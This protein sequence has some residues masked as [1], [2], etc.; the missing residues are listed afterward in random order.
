MRPSGFALDTG[1]TAS[2][3][4]SLTLML[5]IACAVAATGAV[6]SIGL[7]AVALVRNTPILWSIFAVFGFTLAARVCCSGLASLRQSSCG[8]ERAGR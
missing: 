1:H 6:A 5:R 3:R 8:P 7:L 2:H 4:L